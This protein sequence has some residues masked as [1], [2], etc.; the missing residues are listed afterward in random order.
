MEKIKSV[1]MNAKAMLVSASADPVIEINQQRVDKDPLG[2]VVL[3]GQLVNESGQIVNIPHVIA[4]YYDSNGKVIWVSDGY[5][6]QELLPQS[7]VAFAVDLPDDIA[8][9]VQ[10]YRVVVNY[11][12]RTSS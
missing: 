1:R 4:A 8:A 5:V 3:H 12:D 7:P 11:F 10:N 6:E 2:R 9:R